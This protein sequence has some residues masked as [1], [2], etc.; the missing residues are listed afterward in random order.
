MC[1]ILVVLIPKS[2][3]KKEVMSVALAALKAQPPASATTRDG[4][5]KADG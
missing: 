1:V 4:V 5:M 3:R 2:N